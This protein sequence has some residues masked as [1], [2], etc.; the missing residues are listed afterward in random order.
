MFD[1]LSFTFSGL[2]GQAAA[3]IVTEFSMKLDTIKVNWK[4]GKN[5]QRLR[6][7]DSR[8]CEEKGITQHI[9]HFAA[10]KIQI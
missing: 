1:R 8:E 7:H 9:L 5:F 10:G 3:S 2:F 4:K 6:W